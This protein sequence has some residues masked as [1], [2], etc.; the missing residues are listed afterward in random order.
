MGPIPE[1]EIMT[2]GSNTI[3]RYINFREKLEMFDMA[4]SSALHD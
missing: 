3:S 1:Q 4:P 2:G